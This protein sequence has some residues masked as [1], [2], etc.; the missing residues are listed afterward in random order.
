MY[1]SKKIILLDDVQFAKRSWQQRNRIRTH[2]GL[3]WL[4]VRVASKGQQQS[5][6]NTIK[7]AEDFRASELLKPIKY[8]YSKAKYYPKYIDELEHIIKKGIENGK[9]IDLNLIIIEFLLEKLNIKRKIKLS[10]EINVAGKSSE[11]LINLLKEESETKYL[12][13]VGSREY[14]VKD[15]ELFRK[16]KI[17]TKIIEYIPSK[18]NQLHEPF[19]SHAST[20]DILLNYGEETLDV[21]LDG[22]LKV[23]QL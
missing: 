4:T 10:S 21:I 16:S 1:R 8:S 11:Y 17:E 12:S 9:L 18:Y 2:K 20:L 6:I 22:E 23:E 5:L 3:E 14:L 7:L 13:T 19:L 15:R